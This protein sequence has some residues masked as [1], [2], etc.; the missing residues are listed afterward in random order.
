[1]KLSRYRCGEDLERGG[2]NN[3][4]KVYCLNNFLNLV[5]PVPFIPCLYERA[6]LTWHV[7]FVACRVHHWVGALRTFLPQLFGQ[8]FRH[9]GSQF[10]RK[11]FPGHFQLDFY[12]LQSGWV[13]SSAV[14]YYHL[15]LVGNPEPW[16]QLALFRVPLGTPCPRTLREVVHPRH[17]IFI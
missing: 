5:I 12:V 10:P 1:M 6:P 17:W 13:L 3:M 4:I 15:V 14:K 8:H 2:G 7:S 9:N 16:K 11:K